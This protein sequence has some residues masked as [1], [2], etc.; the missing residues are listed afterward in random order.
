MEGLGW[1]VVLFWE[2]VK[3]RKGKERKKENGTNLGA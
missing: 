1:A 3:E 2:G